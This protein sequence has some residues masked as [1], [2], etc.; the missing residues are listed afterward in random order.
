MECLQLSNIHT[1]ETG[2][3]L[4][5]CVNGKWL[6]G[7]RKVVEID[8]T[9]NLISVQLTS[10]DSELIRQCKDS[11]VDIKL[12]ISKQYDYSANCL[13]C[14]VELTEENRIPDENVCVD[15]W[16]QGYCGKI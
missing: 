1:F 8:K 2:D 13:E 11:G 3:G 12:Q 16:N 5:L 14:H 6:D 4:F 10:D 7:T 15:C 9:R